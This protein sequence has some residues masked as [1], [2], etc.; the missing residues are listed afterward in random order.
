MISIAQSFDISA[1]KRHR[2]GM[3][4]EVNE[5]S[6]PAECGIHAQPTTLDGSGN[7]AQE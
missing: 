7:S 5:R 4:V 2:A 1:H 6:E 3:I